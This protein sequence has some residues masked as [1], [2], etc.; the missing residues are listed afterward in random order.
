MDNNQFTLLA[1][2]CL[3][4]VA[5]SLLCSILIIFTASSRPSLMGFIMKWNV[6]NI[7]LVTVWM[8]AM[9]L[10]YGVLHARRRNSEGGKLW[11]VHLELELMLSMN[12]PKRPRHNISKRWS[13]T[14]RSNTKEG[15]FGV[16]KWQGQSSS[17]D[18]ALQRLKKVKDW[19]KLLMR[20]TTSW[21]G[22]NRRTMYPGS[23]LQ[24]GA[25]TSSY[26]FSPADSSMTSSCY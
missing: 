5:L 7:I 13:W 25:S 11:K 2:F 12:I 20:Q 23:S 8:G 16:S 1:W 18:M 19:S 24:N 15:R 6:H 17:F 9:F 4:F 22:K 14:M 10:L 26:C 21:T 3:P